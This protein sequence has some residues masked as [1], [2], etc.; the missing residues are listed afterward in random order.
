MGSFRLRGL[1]IYSEEG[2]QEKNLNPK[3]L[4]SKPLPR[5]PN[6]P[7]YLLMRNVRAL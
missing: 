7:N 4:N 1:E 5:P 6:Y 2:I 3:L